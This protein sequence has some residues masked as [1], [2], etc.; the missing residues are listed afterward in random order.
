MIAVSATHVDSLLARSVALAEQRR[1]LLD[2][3]IRSVL[4]RAVAL[5]ERVVAGIAFDPDEATAIYG[6]MTVL[7]HQVQG[8]QRSVQGSLDLAESVRTSPA[9]SPRSA[10]QR[11]LRRRSRRRCTVL[12]RYRSRETRK[13]VV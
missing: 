6:A 3:G 11:P 7:D 4:G 9:C 1:E 13:G 8:V 12:P 10:Q 2:A 5:W